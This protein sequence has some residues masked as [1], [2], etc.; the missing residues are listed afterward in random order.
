MIIYIVILILCFKVIFIIFGYIKILAI[1]NIYY[2]KL[3]IKIID[4]L[5]QN[6]NN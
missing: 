3:Y 6:I 1:I 4:N 2:I 5:K